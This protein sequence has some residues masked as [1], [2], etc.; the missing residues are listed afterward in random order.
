[1]SSGQ[2]RSDHQH[3]IQEKVNPILEAMVT[4]IL[5]EMPEDPINFMSTWC[6]QQ[7]GDYDNRDPNGEILYLK[8][9]VAELQQQNSELKAQLST[10]EVADEVDEESEEDEDDEMGD[11][12]FEAQ[13]RAFA[14]GEK[15]KMRTSV[16]A[17]A[18]GQFNQRKEFTAPVHPKNEDQTKRLTDTL[19]RSF[20]F[21]NLIDEHFKIII[22]AVEEVKE[23]PTDHVLIKE[24]DSGDCMYIIESGKFIAKKNV[25]DGTTDADGNKNVT[26]QKAVKDCFRGD[27]FG[28]LALLYSTPRAASVV[29]AEPSVVWKLDRDTFN[30]IVK[31]GAMKERQKREAFL[32]NVPILEALNQVERANLSEILKRHVYT[33]KT[34]LIKKGEKGEQFFILESGSAQALGPDGGVLKQYQAKDYFGELALLGNTVRACDVF[35]DPN[36]VVLSVDQASFNRLL[37]KLE[38]IMA[39]AKISQYGSSM[40][41][42]TKAN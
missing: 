19:K 40:I 29:A 36:S 33:A 32:N 41:D 22:D 24:G 12:E 38:K 17:E 2:G 25:Y 3:Y 4:A 31:E 14:Q 16:S 39:D 7:R 9:Q 13:Q 26:E 27:V 21:S 30:A 20:M 28:E 5:L 37:G 8:K 15:S 35:V 1:M 42:V 11:D 34:Q 6:S 18:Y 10:G 23:I